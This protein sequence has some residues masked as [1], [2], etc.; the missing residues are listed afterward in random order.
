MDKSFDIGGSINRHAF[1][2]SMA[3]VILL[4]GIGGWAVSTSFSGAVVAPG[5]LVVSSNLKKVQHPSGG[6]VGLLQVHDGDR[7]RAGQILA[8]LDD[9]IV[10][11]NLGIVSKNLIEL[12][13]RQ[14]RL[15]AEQDDAKAILFPALLSL[16][17]RDE[18]APRAMAI[19][20]RLFLMRFAARSNE[21]AQL[22]ERIAQLHEQ[23][24]GLQEQITAKGKEIRLVQEELKGV[25]MLWQRGLVQF[26]R[27]VSLQRDE[28]RLMGER[29][30]LVSSQA[31]TNGHVTE[32]ELQI[33]QVDQNMRQEVGKELSDIRGR[34]AEL[35]ERKVAAFDQLMRIDI[36]SPQ[37]GV[38][39]QL[40][41][42]TVGGVINAG[43]QIMMI[44]PEGD[45]LEVETKINPQDIDQIHAGQK[46]ILRFPAFNQRTTPEIDGAVTYVAADLTTDAKSGAT[47]YT[48]R[49]AIP[50]D[51][52]A[53]MG[54]AKLVP[55]MPV[56]SFVQTSDRTVISYLTK[57]LA[58]QVNRAFRESR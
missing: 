24:S 55:G 56:E 40:S 13:A 11:A 26:T 38:V 12:T 22:R 14:A 16:D 53:R 44:V 25:M 46:A 9:T 39:H 29:G 31:Q 52:V 47:F 28:A 30:A 37:D 33:L 57:P 20:D 2:G 48:A 17:T 1:A 8:K 41:V 4:G 32:T 5:N 6:V 49:L 36:R 43:E 58:D 18:D 50:A 21:K 10:R 35:S 45:S 51:T 54:G 19:E 42:H 27:V 7:V 34:I 23:V 3:F 15:L